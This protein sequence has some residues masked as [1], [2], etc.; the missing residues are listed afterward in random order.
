MGNFSS[1]FAGNLLHRGV[2]R[3]AGWQIPTLRHGFGQVQA[4]F[5]RA[6]S[7]TLAKDATIAAKGRLD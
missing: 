5:P 1:N 7:K 6:L 3:D 2:F 4:L